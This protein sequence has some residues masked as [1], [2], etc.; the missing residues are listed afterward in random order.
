ME[1]RS[2]SVIYTNL[3]KSSSI[4]KKTSKK[5]IKMT[6]ELRKG[7]G[8]FNVA[9]LARLFSTRSKK[10]LMLAFKRH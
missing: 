7:I 10:V 5:E 2:G 3:F 6:L 1:M 8:W 9:I 4:R